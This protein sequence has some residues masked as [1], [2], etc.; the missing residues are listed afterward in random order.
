MT[1]LDYIKKY[2]ILYFPK[3]MIKLAVRRR[4]GYWPN[5]N[6]PKTFTEKIEWFKLY[7]RDPVITRCAD[8]YLVRDYIER[9]VGRGYLVPLLGVFDS[10]DEID[11]EQMPNQFV[12][13]PNHSSGKVIVCY[14]KNQMDW[15]TE[16]RKMT[17][18]LEQNYYYQTGEWGYKDIKPKIICEKL[19]PGSVIDYRSFCSK[20]IPLLCNLT[21]DAGHSDRQAYVDMGFRAVKDR[22]GRTSDFFKKPKTWEKMCRIAARLSEDFPFVR[23]DLYNIEGKIYFGE[24]TF[25][26]SNGIDPYLSDKWDM[27]LGEKYDLTPFLDEKEKYGIVLQWANC[28]DLINKKEN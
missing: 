3:V 26:P 7:V 28:K 16:K 14:D 13:K 23:V 12:L 1:L 10:V 19:L 4:M 6:N 21:A 18:W 20:G 8:K 11:L 25:S 15:P 22:L 9:K 17:Q 2:G 5:L 24:L 27:I